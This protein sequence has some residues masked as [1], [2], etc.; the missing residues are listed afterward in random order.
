[1]AIKRANKERLARVIAETTGVTVDPD[2][3]FD[4][5]V[6]R[7]HEYKRQLLNVMHIVHEYLCL[8]EDG[9]APSRAPDVR[10]RREGGAGLLGRQADHQ[11]DLQR[12]IGH[13]QRSA[14]ERA[15]Q[16]RVR[17]RLS[18]VAGGTDHPGAR[19]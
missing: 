10:L 11:D 2:S 16:G 12:R 17:S 3:L 5:Q 13:Q 18:R 19:T 6:K 1:M 7:I 15:A 8:I 14:G 4:V 9:T